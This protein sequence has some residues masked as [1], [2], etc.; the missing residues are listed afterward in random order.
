MKKKSKFFKFKKKKIKNLPI[1]SEYNGWN[2]SSIIKIK[3][4]S[5]Q[6]IDNN[7]VI[8]KFSKIA[9]REKI[10]VNTSGLLKIKIKNKK[11]SFKKFDSLSL[12]S[13]KS[14]Y[15]ITCLK[16]SNLFLISSKNYQ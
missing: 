12:F 13:D 1:I 9:N 15:K 6:T 11:Y 5:G 8:K 16:S 14:S 7:L 10:F 4:Y 3:L 2:G